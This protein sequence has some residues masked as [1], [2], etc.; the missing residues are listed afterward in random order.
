MDVVLIVVLAI[1]FLWT[2][3]IVAAVIQAWA[4]GEIEVSGFRDWTDLLL[5]AWF[6]WLRFLWKNPPQ[7]STPR[8]LHWAYAAIHA[9]FWIAC[10]MCGKMYGGHEDTGCIPIMGSPGTGRSV[11]LSCSQKHKEE[12]SK[13]WQEAHQQWQAGK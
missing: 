1:V 7:P 2:L 10:P 13:R 6:S 12:I 5:G 11:C 8:F 9:Y 4:L 3:L